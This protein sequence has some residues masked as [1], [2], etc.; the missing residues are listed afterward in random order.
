M[1]FSAADL[2][3]ADLTSLDLTVDEAFI[4]TSDAHVHAAGAVAAAFAMEPC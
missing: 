3:A 1:D 2:S 4:S